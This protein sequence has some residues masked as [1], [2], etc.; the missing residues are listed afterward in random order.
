[1][2]VLTLALGIGATTAIYTVL[3][4]TFLAPMPLSPSRT[5]GDGVVKKQ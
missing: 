2:A 1:V 3:Y 5:T 4:A